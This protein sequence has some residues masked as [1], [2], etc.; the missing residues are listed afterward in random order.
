MA[1]LERRRRVARE[2]QRV[3]SLAQARQSNKEAH[4]KQVRA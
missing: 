1:P 2:A 4:R 3:R